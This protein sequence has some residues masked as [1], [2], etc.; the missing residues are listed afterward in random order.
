M[1]A[2]P[3][4]TELRQYGVFYVLS[5]VVT[6]AL[7]SSN[8][9]PWHGDNERPMTV[10]IAVLTAIC[11]VAHLA[12]TLRG[13]RR[14]QPAPDWLVTLTWWW[15]FC[16]RVVPAAAP[17]VALGVYLALLGGMWFLGTFFLAFGAAL[18]FEATV[19]AQ[20][21]RTRSARVLR[22]Q[23]RYFVAH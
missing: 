8:D 2:S 20:I 22:F 14:A 12:W 6:I 17:T 7:A 13:L 11:L 23:A 5:G 4:V 1:K 10:A 3:A 16:L 15:T 9:H 19:A 21:E 18:I